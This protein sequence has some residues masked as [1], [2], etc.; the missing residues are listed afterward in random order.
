[1]IVKYKPGDILTDNRGNSV[2]ILELQ[3]ASYIGR[4]IGFLNDRAAF[5]GDSSVIDKMALQV[6][7]LEQRLAEAKVKLASLRVNGHD[8]IGQLHRIERLEAMR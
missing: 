2:E 5:H 8:T 4:R 6:W 1:M 3:G 7:T